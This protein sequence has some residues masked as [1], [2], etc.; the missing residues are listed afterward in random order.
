L[1]EFV[2]KNLP[3]IIDHWNLAIDTGELF[4]RL[5][6]QTRRRPSRG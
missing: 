4:D 5:K 6:R 3:A 1:Q 2:G